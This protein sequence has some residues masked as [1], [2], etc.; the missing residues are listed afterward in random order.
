MVSPATSSCQSAFK[1]PRYRGFIKSPDVTRKQ[2]RTLKPLQTGLGKG[3]ALLKTN[4][5]VPGSSPI[6]DGIGHR[7]VNVR[8][9]N[10]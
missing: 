3:I 9:M 4:L 10:K 7:C 2:M 5:L 8:V 6:T 1:R